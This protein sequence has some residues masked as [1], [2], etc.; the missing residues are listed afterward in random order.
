[1]I[2]TTVSRWIPAVCGRKGG[3]A[4][5]GRE[6][7]AFGHCWVACEGTR[8]CGRSVTAGTGTVREYYREM[9]RVLGTRPHDSFRQDV[10]N[11]ALGRRLAFTPGTCY[12][13]CDGAHRTGAL[14]LSAPMAECVDC[15]T[16]PILTVTTCP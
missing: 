9:Q 12:S 10:A 13:L 3:S 16:Q 6:F 11:Q 8:K 7:D 5:H 14:D 2:D 4:F 15:S 1:M